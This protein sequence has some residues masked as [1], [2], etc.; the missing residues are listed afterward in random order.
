MADANKIGQQT[1][2]VKNLI[3]QFRKDVA[4][5]LLEKERAETAGRQLEAQ[6]ALEKDIAAKYQSTFNKLTPE[7][8]KEYGDIMGFAY[9]TDLA[10]FNAL[11][12]K[13]YA[14]FPIDGYNI[15]MPHAFWGRPKIKP[16]K[17]PY[18]YTPAP[19]KEIVIPHKKGGKIQRFRDV[20][21]QAFLDQQKAIN[22]A[23]NDL[24]NNI[25]KLFIKMM[26]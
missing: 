26:S 4:K 13:H 18:Q 22:K 1:Q 16:Y 17:A 14:N 12:N 19:G 23:V 2:N 25:I 20:D 21:E 9:T 11:K 6:D 8:Q 3:Y 15:G 7:Q 24:N 5:D 10:G